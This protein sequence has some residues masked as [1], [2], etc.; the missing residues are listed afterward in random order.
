MERDRFLS[1]VA[2]SVLTAELPPVPEAGPL[3]EPETA[4]LIASFRSNAQ[5]VSAVVHGPVSRGGV[6]RT[7]AGIASGHAARTFVSWDD[8]GRIPDALVEAG[9]DRV[10]SDWAASESADRLAA[11]RQ[12]DLG[13]TGSSAALAQS[14]SVV[15]IHGPG[16]PRMASLVPDVHIALVEVTTIHFSLAH[17]AAA[18]PSAVTSSANL[19][20]VTGP[21]RSGDIEL[22]LNL[23][24]HGPRNLHVVLI[25]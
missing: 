22:Q 16:R 18:D 4:D 10:R 15:L 12:V 20:V 21:S 1:R 7:V 14:G 8:L 11:Y 3:P 2:A 6:A 17:W 24:V 19:V 13:V 25:D 9:L 23:G 5:A